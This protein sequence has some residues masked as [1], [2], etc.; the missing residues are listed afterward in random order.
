MKTFDKLFYI[1]YRTN[2]IFHSDVFT[3]ALNKSS[4]GHAVIVVTPEEKKLQRLKA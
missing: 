3:F 4:F 1:V 2:Y